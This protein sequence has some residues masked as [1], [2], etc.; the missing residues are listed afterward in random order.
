MADELAML[1]RRT[2][3]ARHP[4]NLRLYEGSP[5]DPDYQRL[6]RDFRR[7][8]WHEIADDVIKYHCN[9]LLLFSSEALAFYLPA[10]MCYVSVRQAP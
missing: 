2:F 4:K 8:S 9:D 7:K 10:F 6:D 3:P 1:L 5:E